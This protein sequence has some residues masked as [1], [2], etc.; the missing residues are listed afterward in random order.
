MNKPTPAVDAEKELSEMLC[1]NEF[2]TFFGVSQKILDQTWKHLTSPDGNSVTYVSM[3]IGSDLDVFNPVRDKLVSLNVD[4]SKDTRLDKFYKL[5]IHGSQ[6]IPN[7]SGGLGILAGDT[8]KSLADCKV[9]TAAI[10]LLYRK[11]Y[12]SQLVD[13][14]LGQ[15]SWAKEWKPEI[16]PSLY[17]LRD[18]KNPEIPLRIHVPF[19]DL[20]DN[21]IDAYAQI[22]IKME[23]NDNLDFFVPE[24]LLDYDIEASPDWIRDAAQHLYDSTSERVKMIQRRMLGAGAI[25]T[26]KALGLTSKTIHL[27]EQHGVAVVLLQI[28]DEL[29]EQFGEKY[30]S[31]AG[32]KEIHEAADK[33]ATKVVYTIHTPVKAGHDKFD[34]KLY[35]T[36]S[37]SFCQKI[38]GILA[39]DK[40]SPSSFN[41]TDLAMKVNRSTNSVSRLHKKVTQKQFPQYAEK[42]SAIT[43]GVHHLTWISESKA[44]L[45]DSF[46]ELKGWRKDP[47]VFKNAESLLDNIRFHTYLEDAWKKD[48]AILIDYLNSMLIAHRTQMHETWIDPPN[49]LS[50]LNEV[51]SRLQ[52][53]VFSIGFARRFSTYKRA[54]LIFE[55][56]DALLEPI[57]ANDWPV[58]FI[59]SGKAHPSDEP[60]KTLIKIILDCQHELYDKSN[61]LVKLIFIP[62]YDMEIAKMMVSG[63]HAWLNSP[64]RPLE[65]SGT[66]GM[67]AAMNGVPNISIMDGWWAEGYHAGQTGW[68]FGY[69]TAIDEEMLS[70]HRASL[71][72]EE[73]SKSFYKVFPEIIKTFYDHELRR[74]YLKKSIMNLALNCPIFNTHRMIA[75][76]A[77]RYNISFPTSTAR[78]LHKLREL[79]SSDD[80]YYSRKHSAGNTT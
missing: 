43:N 74:E 71:L 51:D 59:F 48:N 54:D 60:G 32:E 39:K 66:S 69:E 70:E 33:V 45:Y 35:Q 30:F 11:G 53:G 22:W 80:E 72:Y 2:G 61:G 73:D 31:L 38:L 41:F 8:L 16:T 13:S 47:G 67:K 28:V 63:V 5:F 7:Y 44:D 18:P 15:I 42:I 9:P 79:Y 26:M 34:Q 76:Y 4:G 49:Y 52:P 78:K 17:L 77:D 10:S 3:E 57:V 58:N 55:D 6:K 36:V 46:P 50:Q 23:I 65:A 25:P 1:S 27:N 19:Y 75:E 40:D 64:K 21:I 20:N 12:F 68:K 29:T 37:H 24:I 56:I 14:Q 62:G